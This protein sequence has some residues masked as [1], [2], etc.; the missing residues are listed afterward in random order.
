MFQ[1]VVHDAR[2]I[3]A[4][5]F[6]EQFTHKPERGSNAEGGRRTPIAKSVVA[7]GSRWRRERVYCAWVFVCTSEC[8][9]DSVRRSRRPWAR[10]P[11]PPIDRPKPVC[12]RSPNIVM[13]TAINTSPTSSR[14]AGIRRDERTCVWRFIMEDAGCG[15]RRELSRC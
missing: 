10:P 14:S 4:R 1:W 7:R 11:P 13:R 15:A 9:P 3:R 2:V 12:F 8:T 5:V 6:Q